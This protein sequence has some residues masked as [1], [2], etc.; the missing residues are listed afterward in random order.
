MSNS[1][2]ATIVPVM[3]RALFGRTLPRGM[4]VMVSESEALEHRTS[5]LGQL[6]PTPSGGGFCSLLWSG[7]ASGQ[8]CLASA[9]REHGFVGYNSQN[10]L[11]YRYPASSG[12]HCEGFP[13]GFNGCGQWPGT[14]QVGSVCDFVGIHSFL[15]DFTSNARRMLVLLRPL[16]LRRYQLGHMI[17]SRAMEAGKITEAT[18]R[19]LD[20]KILY[21]DQQTGGGRQNGRVTLESMTHLRIVLRVS[22]SQHSTAAQQ[23]QQRQG[24]RVTGPHDTCVHVSS[25][26]GEIY[27]RV[28]IQ[29][30]PGTGFKLFFPRMTHPLVVHLENLLNVYATNITLFVALLSITLPPLCVLT[31]V[32][33]S[34]PA[35]I[36]T[37][38]LTVIPK[39]ACQIGL[40]VRNR[41]GVVMTFE[42]RQ[43]VR[44]EDGVVKGRRV[45]SLAQA[46]TVDT[47]QL[48]AELNRL[49]V[50]MSQL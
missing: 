29:Y 14:G 32:L 18:A 8:L 46:R 4:L 37:V 12:V 30:I 2:A 3:E 1:T 31:A 21:M 27:H 17:V 42:R 25:A 44:I 50:E 43:R 28:I 38:N 45:P 22:C 35:G 24:A 6:L 41:C 39:T 11:V 20:N 10:Q 36:D 34:P 40:V 9:V 47:V 7:V 15:R 23:S 5:T 26:T 33:A 13:G 48:Q 16:H 49:L 19:I